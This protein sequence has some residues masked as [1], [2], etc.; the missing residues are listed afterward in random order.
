MWNSVL[1]SLWRAISGFCATAISCS[2][3]RR[4][5]KSGVG[6]ERRPKKRKKIRKREVKEVTP[7]KRNA[8]R[9][10]APEGV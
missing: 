5:L 8:K 2:S 9:A 7:Q 10:A 4:Y 1:Q 3:S 6:E